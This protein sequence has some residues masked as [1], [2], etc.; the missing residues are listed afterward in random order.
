MGNGSFAAGKAG[1]GACGH[2]G[3]IKPVQL[4]HVEN[5]E[6]LCSQA[7]SASLP[8]TC[9]VRALSVSLQLSS[10]QHGLMESINT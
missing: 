10:V 9:S 3:N 1:V 8:V 2:T 4:P 6:Q 5:G 7:S